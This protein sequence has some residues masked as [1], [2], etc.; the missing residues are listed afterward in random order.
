MQKNYEETS[1]QMVKMATAELQ[2]KF[3]VTKVENTRLN[4]QLRQASQTSKNLIIYLI[5][6]A[7]IGLVIG[8]L[9]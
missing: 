6:A 3:D 5:I 4:D 2:T 1:K 8:L 7:I 9:I